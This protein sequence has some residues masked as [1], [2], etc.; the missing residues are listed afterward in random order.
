[1]STVISAVLPLTAIYLA[2]WL[3][4]AIYRLTHHPLAGF[5]GPKLAAV[6]SLY[7]GWYDLRYTT[8]FVR[9]FS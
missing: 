7:G 8:S 3:T 1:M 5:P 2:Y 9:Q 6:T 4:R